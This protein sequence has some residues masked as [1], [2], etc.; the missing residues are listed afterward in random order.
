MVN[1]RIRVGRSES[2]LIK[3]GDQAGC[4][5]N[6]PNLLREVEIFKGDLGEIT[7]A[8]NNKNVDQCRTSDKKYLK[9]PVDPN[10]QR[11]KRRQ[12]GDSHQ[13]KDQHKGNA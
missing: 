10:H 11:S 9:F 8:D 5:K 4:Q 2:C 6:Q 1:T 3:R 12:R 7:A 13:P